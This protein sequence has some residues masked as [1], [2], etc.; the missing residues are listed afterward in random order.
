[1]FHNLLSSSLRTAGRAS[2]P[3]RSDRLRRRA[4]LHLERMEDR[5]CPSAITFP[6]V[7]TGWWNNL[8]NHTASNQNYIVGQNSPTQQLRNFA[9]FDLAGFGQPIASGRLQLINPANG[10]SSPDPTETWTL[11]DITTPIAE[12][13]ANGAG[14]VDIYND[15]GSGVTHGQRNISLADNGQ[16]ISV[17]LNGAALSYLQ[18]QLGNLVALGGAITTIDGTANQFAFGFSGAT[19]V[20]QLI[21]DARTSTWPIALVHTPDRTQGP[22]TSIRV[23]FDRSMR[24]DTFTTDDIGF[25]QGPVGDIPVNSVNVVPN[26]GNR[27][28]DIHFPAQ[29][30]T[31][32]YEMHIGPHILDAAGNPMDQDQ[33]GIPGQAGDFYSTAAVAFGRVYVTSKD[34]RVY[35]FDKETGDLAWS[36]TAGGELYAGIV[37]ADTPNT[38]PSVY[39]GSYGGGRFYSLDARSGDENWSIDA[40][41][42][43]IGAASLIGETVY[44]ANLQETDTIAV[45]AS[46]G[47]EVWRFRDGAYNP[48][49]SD[50]KRLYLTGYKHLYA[51]KRVTGKQRAGKSKKTGVKLSAAARARKAVRVRKKRESRRNL[52]I[53]RMKAN[54][55]WRGKRKA[56][57]TGY[58]QKKGKK[59]PK[60]G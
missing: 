29:F 6:A 42:P 26:S 38:E 17:E 15:L 52:K 58:R 45:N 8:G 59:K 2:R 35:S 36:R 27:E 40:G 33:D 60:N 50:G 57:M 28:F 47:G 12:L 19:G 32:I 3:D 51:M 56:V 22:L 7:Q 23:R 4:R 30:V 43:V 14:R 37:A 39:F 18:S 20:R 31:S 24:P 21:L 11:F 44:F 13:R 48:V 53:K 46:N 49:I 34:G 1:M 9:V 25:F 55:T 16:V 10:Y 41:G 5:A 54:G